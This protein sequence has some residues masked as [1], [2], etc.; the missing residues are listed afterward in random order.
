M[1]VVIACRYFNDVLHIAE[2][3]ATT[4]ATQIGHRVEEATEWRHRLE[5]Q[6]AQPEMS[7]SIL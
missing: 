4:N 3:G 2:L 7:I 1:G 6:S 5:M